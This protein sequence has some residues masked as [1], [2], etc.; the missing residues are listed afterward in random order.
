[1]SGG[2]ING[3]ALAKKMLC[4]VSEL[5]QKEKQAQVL[6]KA[7]EQPRLAIILVGDNPFS[8]SYI[9]RKRYIAQKIHIKSRL[10]QIEDLPDPHHTTHALEATLRKL[11]QDPKYHGILLQLP[12]PPRLR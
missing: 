10:F 7:F 3:V 6:S 8:Q 1:M 5:I 2:K 12:L 11:N 9:R 4:E